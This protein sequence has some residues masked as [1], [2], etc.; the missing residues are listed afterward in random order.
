MEEIT[1][2]QM[3]VIPKPPVNP[4]ADAV[5]V[6]GFGEMV[7]TVVDDPTKK[8]DCRKL[9]EPLEKKKKDPIETLADLLMLNPDEMDEATERFNYNMQEAIKIAEERLKTQNA[10]RKD[11]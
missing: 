10:E 1:D 5:G 11:G 8:A 3:A 7:C 2:D 9:L 6:I 4:I